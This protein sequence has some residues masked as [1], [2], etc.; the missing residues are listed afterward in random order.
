MKKLLLV[1]TIVFITISLNAI[2]TLSVGFDSGFVQDFI[3]NK[4]AIQLSADARFKFEDICEIRIP[5]TFSVKKSDMLFDTGIYAICYPYK[6]LFFG[7]SIFETGITKKQ[8]MI[9]N[10]IMAGWTF[11]VKER[12]FI[13]PCLVI[14]DPSG[15]YS[16]EYS[17]LKGSFPC[18]RTY[19]L[20]L[21]VG[22]QFELGA[23]K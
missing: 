1:L 12:W 16:Q 6:G 19:R 23:E 5:L 9:L 13:E 18:Y 21:N 14:K 7:I 20:R 4:T 15:S 11:K 3:R 22:A 10:E 2:P 17:A 8:T